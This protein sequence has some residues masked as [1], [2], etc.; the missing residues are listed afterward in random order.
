MKYISGLFLEECKNR[1]LAWVLVDGVEELCYIPSSAKLSNFLTMEGRAVLLSPNQKPGRTKFTV[2]AA[3]NDDETYCYLYLNNIN[4]LLRQYLQ[5][6]YTDV[7]DL[8]KKLYWG[9]RADLVLH[10]DVE[11][12]I[13]AKGIISENE[14]IM[15]PLVCGERALRQLDD[16]SKALG[17]QF[18]VTYCL[19]LASPQ[20]KE[21][22]FNYK[23]KPY[24]DKLL[25]CFRLGMKINIYQII[26]KE[27]DFICVPAKKIT[28]D[29]NEEFTN[30][31]A[32][33]GGDY[34][35]DNST[36]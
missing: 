12:I 8:E 22:T 25:E 20:I 21:I 27:Q 13:E 18:N 5:S 36:I 7:I 4:N 23:Y 24:M 1:F 26:W 6:K 14:K 15:F 17:K 35:T 9:Y 31:L 10:N 19:V 28:F 33:Q 32:S 3:V 2:V 16:F 11:T 30:M 29:I 34:A